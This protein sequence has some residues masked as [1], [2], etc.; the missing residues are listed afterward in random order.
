MDPSFQKLKTDMYVASSNFLNE[1][2]PLYMQVDISFTY[3]MHIFM[4]RFR[5][6]ATS[7]VYFTVY[8]PEEIR[9]E[10]RPHKNA[11]NDSSYFRT[12]KSVLER[13]SNAACE[14]K[15]MEAFDKV[16]QCLCVY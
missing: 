16:Y 8:S 3:F 15:P 2:V 4:Y 11:K 6:Q 1:E 5:R 14:S 7:F 9:V 12:K 13:I 10:V